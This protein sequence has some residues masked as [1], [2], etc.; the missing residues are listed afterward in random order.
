MKEKA[1]KRGQRQLLLL[2]FVGLLLNDFCIDQVGW[3][4][5]VKKGV[6]ILM[7][8]GNVCGRQSTCYVPSKSPE[9]CMCV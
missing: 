8:K 6:Y 9:S 2:L 1:V 4:S 5:H 3:L 7:S